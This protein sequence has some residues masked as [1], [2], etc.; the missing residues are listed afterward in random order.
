MFS[1]Q[2]FIKLTPSEQ[3]ALSLGQFA[4]ATAME[5]RDRP[6]RRALAEAE[7]LLLAG[8]INGD[9][10]L[11]SLRD[12]TTEWRHAFEDVSATLRKAAGRTDLLALELCT[13]SPLI[14]AG[15]LGASPAVRRLNAILDY[16][17]V[18][19]SASDAQMAFVSCLEEL[20]PVGAEF[21]SQDMVRAAEWAANALSIAHPLIGGAASIG[22]GLLG[23]RDKESS[24][25]DEPVE[26][27]PEL[28]RL[29]ASC[30][31]ALAE[32]DVAA[33]A[34]S[35]RSLIATALVDTS[36]R[37]AKDVERV[38]LGQGS[39]SA[40][41][42]RER[43][44]RHAMLVNALELLSAFDEDGGVALDVTIP[45]VVGMRLS[46]ASRTLAAFGAQM[47]AFDC[48]QPTGSP[49]MIWSEANWRIVTQERG[50][51]GEIRL[52]VLKY[53]ES[54]PANA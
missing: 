16:L 18:D 33:V 37:L 48:L 52:G 15:E 6:L 23:G 40:S 28:A 43:E 9:D 13:H 19:F 26:G 42:L 20:D 24:S 44:R 34:A 49:R 10:F 3:V 12:N 54:V 1:L 39:V 32:S 14:D 46:D 11:S 25:S 41:T 8:G 36:S 21:V 50:S 5:V 35:A 29:I 22:V 38:R 7:P 45:D 47:A 31:H 17:D 2:Q 4:V 30:R 27:A 51:T 53:G